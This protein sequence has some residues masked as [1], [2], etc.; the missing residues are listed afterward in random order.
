[1]YCRTEY[2]VN[3]FFPYTVKEWAIP[4]KAKQGVGLITCFFEN[5]CKFR[6]FS[7]SLEIPDKTV[8]NPWIFHKIELNPLEIPRKKTKAHGN[9]TLYFPGHPWKF[10]VV[11][12][13]PLPNYYRV[14][15]L[16]SF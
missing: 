7:L 2:F 5:P 3:S 15:S 1:M 9:S 10:E 6:F 14:D 13:E 16:D 11:E 4:E 12:K 8:I